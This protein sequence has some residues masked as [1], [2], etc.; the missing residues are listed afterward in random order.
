MKDANQYQNELVSQIST[1]VMMKLPELIAKKMDQF[2]ITYDDNIA[3]AMSEIYAEGLNEGLSRATQVM[4]HAL[5]YKT[6]KDLLEG[7]ENE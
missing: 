6:T 1:E 2:K 4:Q 3:D 5:L 7:S